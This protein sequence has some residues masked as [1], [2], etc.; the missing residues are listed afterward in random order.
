MSA[1]KAI[2]ERVGH[3]AAQQLQEMIQAVHETATVRLEMHDFPRAWRGELLAIAAAN[4]NGNAYSQEQV[5]RA[6]EK[7]VDRLERNIA[8]DVAKRIVP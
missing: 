5:T 3:Q 6:R 8:V 1:S 4:F 7:I 2:D